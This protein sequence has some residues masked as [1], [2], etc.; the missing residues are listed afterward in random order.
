MGKDRVGEMKKGKGKQKK[1]IQMKYDDCKVQGFKYKLL[2][3]N[4]ESNDR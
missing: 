1:W 3:R 2:T 4:S